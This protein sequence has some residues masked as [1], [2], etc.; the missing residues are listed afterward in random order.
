MVSIG[1]VHKE[2]N[3]KKIDIITVDAGTF[4]TTVFANGIIEKVWFD[5]NTIADN[6]NVTLTDTITGEVIIDFNTLSADK[7][8][9]PKKAA[10]DINGTNLSA[11]A[12]IYTKFCAGQVTLTIDTGGSVKSG[13]FYIWVS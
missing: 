1:T 9:Y 13:I 8:A 10:Q 11:D 12:N 5:K 4:S 7:L 2:L 3:C 6:V